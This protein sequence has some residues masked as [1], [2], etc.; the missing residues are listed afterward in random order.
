M[1]V[2]APPVLIK[3]TQVQQPDKQLRGSRIR[4]DKEVDQVD[5]ASKVQQPDKHVRGFKSSQVD[6]GRSRLIQA[7]KSGKPG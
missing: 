1:T 7:S 2:R 4:L 5:Q 6:Q 3:R